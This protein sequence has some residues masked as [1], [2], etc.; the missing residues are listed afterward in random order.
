MSGRTLFIG[1]QRWAS[2]GLTSRVAR[3]KNSVANGYSQ[4]ENTLIRNWQ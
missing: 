1:F 2:I 4:V 3:G